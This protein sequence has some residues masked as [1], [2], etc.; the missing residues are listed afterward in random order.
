MLWLAPAGVR[1]G[2]KLE[3]C[4]Q[5]R[6]PQP[7]SLCGPLRS[8][9]LVCS[10]R[11]VAASFLTRCRGSRLLR[12]RRCGDFG[13]VSRLKPAEHRERWTIQDFLMGALHIATFGSLCQRRCGVFCADCC[14]S[15]NLENLRLPL[16]LLLWQQQ[17]TTA[18]TLRRPFCQL[19]RHRQSTSQRDRSPTLVITSTWKG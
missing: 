5:S 2:I 7:F 18:K 4:R 11:D 6:Q 15:G 17:S 10:T 1:G 12:P 14:G 9:T 13:F 8:G 19:S 16:C 3:A